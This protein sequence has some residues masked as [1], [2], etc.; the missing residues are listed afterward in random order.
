MLYIHII[1]KQQTENS[2]PLAYCSYSPLLLPLE[3]SFLSPV[4][5]LG[6]VTRITHRAC[7]LYT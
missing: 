1:I 5:R 4:F 2:S 6:H 7:I 3:S